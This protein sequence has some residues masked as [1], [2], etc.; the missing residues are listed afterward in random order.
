MNPNATR[1]YA[2][3]LDVW[4]NTISAKI[5][6]LLFKD[7]QDAEKRKASASTAAKQPSINDPLWVRK[8]Y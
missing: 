8:I 3:G 5:H 4:G 6:I 1:F 7:P 2:E